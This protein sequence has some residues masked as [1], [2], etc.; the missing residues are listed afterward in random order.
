M[1]AFRLREMRK[2]AGM[3]ATTLAEIEAIAEACPGWGDWDEAAG[4]A[5]RDLL[6][7]LRRLEWRPIETAPNYE[8]VLVWLPVFGAAAG[9]LGRYGWMI[10]K[11]SIIGRGTA[12]LGIEPTHWMPLPEPPSDD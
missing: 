11:R 10:G 1:T 3:S 12:A 4:A 9:T 2:R 6:A 5:I 7:E 8:E